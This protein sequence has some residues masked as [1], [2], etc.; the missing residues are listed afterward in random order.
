MG[1]LD[2]TVQVINISPKATKQDLITLFSYCGTV[3]EIKLEWDANGTQAAK[4]TFRQPYAFQTALLF[5]N[6]IIIDRRVRILP[7][8]MKEIP[9][10]LSQSEDRSTQLVTNRPVQTRL[11]E[12]EIIAKAKD[13]VLNT[14]RILTQ[15]SG[16]VIS[17]AE[18]IADEIGSN[19]INSECFSQGAGWL[20]GVLD[21]ASKSLA[22]LS[23]G[24]K[25]PR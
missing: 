11:K 9:I 21:K 8:E 6:A 20:S 14:G 4:V 23:N 13:L 3:R 18:R 22:E 19:V 24:T 5:N 2:F 1:I 15:Q 17:T 10:S 7:L 16:S 25:G 12:E